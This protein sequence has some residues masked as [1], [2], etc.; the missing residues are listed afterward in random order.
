MM[1]KFVSFSLEA[2]MLF[3]ACTAMAAPDDIV[4]A[5]DAER[6]AMISRARVWVPTD[7]ASKDLLNGPRGGYRFGQTVKCTFE[8]PD[9]E[10]P[11]GGYTPKFNCTNAA[12][13]S[14]RIKYGAD[15]GEVPAEIAA[16]RLLWAL[17][18]AADT[19][20]PVR[21]ECRSCPRDPWV[22][23]RRKIHPHRSTEARTSAHLR[24]AM[25]RG[26]FIFIPALVEDRYPGRRIEQHN[27][28]G[29]VFKELL[30]F[31]NVSAEEQMHREAL[32][33]LLSML[34]HADNKAEQQRMMCPDEEV[35][36]LAGGRTSCRTPIL[37]VHDLG[38]TFGHGWNIERDLFDSKM[39]LRDWQ[40]TPVWKDRATCRAGVNKLPIMNTFVTINVHERSRAFLASLMQQL[41][42]KQIEDLFRAAR[43]DLQAPI[44]VS[45]AI[46]QRRVGQWA[47][48]FEAKRREIVETRCPQ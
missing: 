13:K 17:G 41:S 9:P 27:D 21:V 7:V 25:E 10:D 37:L 26:D 22:Y 43:V 32:V 19:N 40:A 20:S 11:P 42:R 14:L 39:D 35:V 12:G 34:Q 31:T 16:S 8:E 1:R 38:W 36:Q 28:Q 46:G 4:P 44:P 48:L 24:T 5:S 29:W 6:A 47:D 23:I 3:A 15:N 45:Y 2:G 18:F 33:L 30:D